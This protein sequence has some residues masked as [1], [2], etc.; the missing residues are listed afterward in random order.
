MYDQVYFILSG[1]SCNWL[2]DISYAITDIRQW[3][4]LAC[5]VVTKKKTIPFDLMP[6]KQLH[7]VP[8]SFNAFP[9]FFISPSV[10]AV[11]IVVGG[12]DVN[13]VAYKNWGNQKNM[14]CGTLYIPANIRF[15]LMG[16]H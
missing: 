3:G 7:L 5:S 9:P 16:Q 6:R 11:N 15:S 8:Q 13:R 4:I 14:T 10:L 1:M 12:G 2:S